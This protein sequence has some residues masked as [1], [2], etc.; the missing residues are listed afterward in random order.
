MKLK[1]VG[2]MTVLMLVV[3]VQ[4]YAC[5]GSCRSG[6]CGSNDSCGG[7]SGSCSCRDRQATSQQN[8][9]PANTEKIVKKEEGGNKI[10]PIEGTK[11]GSM[12]EAV[13]VEYKSKVYNL[14]CG[15]CIKKFEKNPKKYS[16][17]ADRE[18]TN[19]ATK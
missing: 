18:I 11:I 4:V 14:C 10:C 12:G 15:T 6:S 9:P 5:G 8:V 7:G 13:N 1:I 3:S 19:N 17:I 16:K 2:V